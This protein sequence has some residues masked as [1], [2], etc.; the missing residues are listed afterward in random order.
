MPKNSGLTLIELLIVISIIAILS[1][2]GT[3]IFFGAV[4]N[5]RDAR[6]KAD[7]EAISLAWEVNYTRGSPAYPVLSSGWFVNNSIPKDPS[8]GVSY[9][10]TGANEST[11]ADTYTVCANLESGGSFCQSNQQ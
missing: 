10:Y 3:L 1:T 2:I 11:G 6:R 9:S 7:I 5:A 8:T 4:K